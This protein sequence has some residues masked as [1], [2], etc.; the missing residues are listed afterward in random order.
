MPEAGLHHSTYAFEDVCVGE[1]MS[2]WPTAQYGAFETVASPGDVLIDPSTGRRLRFRLTAAQTGGRLVEYAIQF[3]PSEPRPAIEH[4]DQDREHV[5]E[6]L[7]G[8][9]RAIVAGHPQRLGPGDV[10]L[11]GRGESYRMWNAFEAAAE[12]VW[13]T[14]PARD[15]EARLQARYQRPRSPGM[16]ELSDSLDA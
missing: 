14:L 2:A 9:L 1:P 11:I 12:A 13:Q 8:R 6:V 4:V 10:L 16:P 3:S 5:V 7:R 15:Q